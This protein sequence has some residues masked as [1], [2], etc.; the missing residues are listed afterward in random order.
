VEV[1]REER[2]ETAA[3]LCGIVV[4][5]ERDP[6]CRVVAAELAAEAGFGEDAPDDPAQPFTLMTAAQQAADAFET[7]TR[8]DET[9]YVRLKDDAPSWIGE[10][11]Q[12]AHGDF[13]PDDWRYAYIAESFRLIADAGEDED[14]DELANQFADD[15][16]VYTGNLL[17]WLGS[18]LRR[19]GYVDEARD[20]YGA[21]SFESV[22]QEIAAGQAA[23]RREV[24]AAIRQAV[25]EQA[26]RQGSCERGRR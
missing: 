9:R 26:T 25:E 18:N 17:G 15:A 21:A 2:W 8:E 6:Y 5:S 1:R 24:F 4:E 3:S 22:A 13:L 23:E 16:D 20:E 10:A 12:A 11:V 19:V 14:L 7:A